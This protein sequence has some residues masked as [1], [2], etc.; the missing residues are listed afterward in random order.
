MAAVGLYCCMWAFYSCG[1]HG[2]LFFVVHRLLIAVA[3]LLAEHRLKAQGF[4][5]RNT[6]AQ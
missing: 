3:S 6:R 1:K 5:S 2:L 4:S